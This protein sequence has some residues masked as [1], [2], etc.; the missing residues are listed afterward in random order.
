M[1]KVD[2]RNFL[3]LA[4]A[5]VGAVAL[6][7]VPMG[8][9]SGFGGMA[10]HEATFSFVA[11]GPVPA[12]ARPTFGSLLLRGHI[13]AKDRVSGLVNQRIVAGYPAKARALAFSRLGFT[14]RIDR[15]QNGQTIELSGTVED[16][17]APH[18]RRDRNFHLSIDRGAGIVTYRFQGRSHQLQL[19]E[20]NAQ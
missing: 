18:Y 1:K 3:K 4:G 17:A 19:K 8:L 20:F 5:G 2:R 10:G 11:E 15:A 13:S 7:T 14:G 6:S 12:G 16:A 9:L